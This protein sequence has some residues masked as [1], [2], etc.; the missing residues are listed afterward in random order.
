MLASILTSDQLS[1][2]NTG[3]IHNPKQI[4]AHL[5]K[6]SCYSRNTKARCCFWR[7]Y[8]MMAPILPSQQLSIPGESITTKGEMPTS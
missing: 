8:I 6:P 1:G 3:R 4:I 5:I 2:L 7:T